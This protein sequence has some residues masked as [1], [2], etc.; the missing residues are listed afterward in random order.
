[1]NATAEGGHAKGRL[2]RY[3]SGSAE[4]MSAL[5][6]GAQRGVSN[7]QPTVTWLAMNEVAKAPLGFNLA[8]AGHVSRQSVLAVVPGALPGTDRCRAAAAVNERGRVDEPALAR[9]GPRAPRP[10]P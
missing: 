10:Q 3:A 2:G 4:R 8:A 7:H 1:M 5:K 6:N 9:N